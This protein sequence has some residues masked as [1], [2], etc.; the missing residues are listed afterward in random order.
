MLPFHHPEVTA[1]RRTEGPR[2]RRALA[3]ALVLSLAAA[4]L[5]AQTAPDPPN[6]DPLGG[7][8][9]QALEGNLGL[10]QEQLSA[11]RADAAVREA[12]GLY[13]PSLTFDSRYSEM[14]GG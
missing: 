14:R 1:M 12:R 11:D 13:L 4:P 5:A 8:V 9:R 3:A 7:Y 2:F 10:R 6:P